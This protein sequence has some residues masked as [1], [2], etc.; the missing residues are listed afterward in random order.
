MKVRAFFNSK[1]IESDMVNSGLTAVRLW[2]RVHKKHPRILYDAVV[3]VVSGRSNKQEVVKAIADELGA[4]VES[5]RT[6]RPVGIRPDGRAGK[7]RGL[8]KKA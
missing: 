1:K 8:R 3:R 5:Y 7:R 2:E 4:T 6:K